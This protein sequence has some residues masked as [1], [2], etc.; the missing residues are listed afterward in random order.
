MKYWWVSQNKTYK[1]EQNNNFM[2]SPKTKS[3][4]HKNQHYTNMT[5]CSPGDI[6]LA[7]N[8]GKIS[9]YGIVQAPAESYPKPVFENTNNNWSNEGWLVAVN[10]SKLNKEVKPSEI[11]QELKPHLPTKY[12]PLK[13]D[14]S[15]QEAY[16]SEIN[17]DILTIILKHSD[18]ELNDIINTTSILSISSAQR[19]LINQ[20]QQNTKIDSTEKEQLIK[21]R[22]GQ[23]R[24]KSNLTDFENECRF[25]K[26][27]DIDLLIASHI[28]P[29]SKCNTNE[30]RLDGNNGLLL[31]PTFDRLFD[32]GLLSFLE[33][34]DVILSKD[35]SNDVI[36]KLSLESYTNVGSFNKEQS[37]YLSYHRTT[38]FRGDLE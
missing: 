22:V 2:W 35:L 5:M 25:T 38:V 14:G 17:L 21:A 33:N 3:N 36:E 8:K 24:F 19:L 10:W 9:D 31:T 28:K 6:V 16:L 37:K 7:F 11:I 20:I 15:G 30:E 23:G 34:G 12:S 1:E 4:G 32:K 29:W 13:Q 26:V 18:T 27:N